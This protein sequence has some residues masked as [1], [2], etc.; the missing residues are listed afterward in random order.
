LDFFR[1]VECLP[2]SIISLSSDSKSRGK[3]EPYRNL[4]RLH[5]LREISLEFRCHLQEPQQDS[6][7]QEEILDIIKWM[8][9][10]SKLEYVRL[11]LYNDIRTEAT[12]WRDRVVVTGEGHYQRA[13]WVE[14][15]E[16]F[17][18]KEVYEE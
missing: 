5:R 18:W 17:V 6:V 16:E 13:K 9:N 15:G 1:W 10:H 2:V 11:R 14:R 3:I 7:V 4:S 12:I 8:Q